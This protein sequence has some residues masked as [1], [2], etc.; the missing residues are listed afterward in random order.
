MKTAIIYIIL[1]NIIGLIFLF[2]SYLFIKNKTKLR[3]VLL[4]Y[5]LI[6]LFFYCFGYYIFNVFMSIEIKNYLS[7]CFFPSFSIFFLASFNRLKAGNSDN[8]RSDIIR[9]I[10]KNFIKDIDN[11]AEF[12]T[13]QG[14]IIINNFFTHFLVVAGTRG[15]KTKSVGFPLLKQYMINKFGGFVYDAKE[16]DYTKATLYFKEKLKTDIP[17]YHLN[18]KDT[19]KT[20]RCNIIDPSVIKEYTFLAEIIRDIGVS[21]SEE[22]SKKDEWFN[23]GLGVVQAV[24][25]RFFYDFPHMCNIGYIS[26]FFIKKNADEIVEFV[27]QR[28]ESKI[29]ADELIK[30]KNSPKTM[31]N[32]LWSASQIVK[33]IASNKNICYV[34]GGDDFKFNL[35]EKDK[36]K[37]ITVSND[38]KNASVLNGFI[39]SMVNI[40]CRH[41]DYGNK[42]KIFFFMDEGTTFKIPNFSHLVGLLAEY[43]VS[44]TFLTQS[45]SKIEEVYKTIAKTSI[46]ANFNNKFLGRTNVPKDAGEYSNI[47]GS[48]RTEKKSTSKGTSTNERNTSSSK[49]ESI[50]ELKENVFYSDHFMNQEP[51]EFTCTFL[52]ANYKSGVFNFEMENLNI[53]E[54]DKVNLTTDKSQTKDRVEDY[55]NEMILNID[56]M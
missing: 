19:T 7:Y 42:Q 33:P 51:G 24:A 5:L 23:A 56:K 50:T 36:P 55:Y 2:I 29:Y 8:L 41:I 39:G 22:D 31:S 14:K 30:S 28:I 10:K 44:F 15:G 34:L 52:D 16:F 38:Q 18:F 37:I 9:P 12:F 54:L 25:V 1:F 49:G 17:I 13:K 46:I 11:H 27:E 48:T 40:L 26:I 35:I 43:R 53:E 21:V 3:Y 32:I 6:V 45:I 20:F 4:K 47:F